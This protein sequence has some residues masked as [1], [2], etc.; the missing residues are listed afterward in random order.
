MTEKSSVDR[1][2][3]EAFAARLR[4]NLARIR[5]E[6]AAACAACSRAEEE[7]TLLGVTKTVP[8]DRINMA[9]EAG[10]TALGKTGCRNSSK[11]G[12]SCGWRG[13]A[14]I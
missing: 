3:Q 9:I 4:D 11:S 6:I 5:E 13:S 10:L 8:A 12:R 14:F 1:P 7:I 2:E